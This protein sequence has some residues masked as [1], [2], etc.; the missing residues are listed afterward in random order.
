MMSRHRLSLAAAIL[1]LGAMTMSALEAR[2]GLVKI[3]VDESSARFSLYRLVDVAKDR[4]EAL[5]FDLDPRT[6]SMTLSFGG[7]QYRLGDSSEF[8]QAVA[9]TA[10]G[11]SI[12]FRS[13][14]ARVTEHLDFARSS[15][16][17]IADGIRLS[18]MM[19]NVSQKEASV[20][21]RFLVDTSLAEKSGIHF[22]LPGLEKMSNETVFEGASIPDW[23]ETPGDTASFMIQ[24]TGDGIVTPDRVHFA[25]WKRL[26]EAP[27]IL[28]SSSARNFTLLPYSINDS[29]VAIYWLPKVLAPGASSSVALAMGAFNDK[30]YPISQGGD[31]GTDELFSKTVLT[32][33]A[34]ADK[35]SLMEADLLSVRDLLTRIDLV[36]SSGSQPTADEIAAWKKILD[37]LEERKKGY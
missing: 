3:V 11:V 19:E 5:F 37:L 27:W 7:R 16:A 22:R 31:K 28:E 18:I 25:N 4:Y 10:T 6:T 21:L 2:E 1:L 26:N 33:P 32:Q 20:G 35:K 13:A 29:A 15:G 8:R 24:F 36:L 14:F 9:R 34:N 12:E 17:A 23:V 30:G